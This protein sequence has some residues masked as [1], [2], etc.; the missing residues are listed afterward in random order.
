MKLRLR[1]QYHVFYRKFGY[2]NLEK[3]PNIEQYM[4]MNLKKLKKEKKEKE[5]KLMR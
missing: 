3:Q 4:A 2:N 5:N 1:D